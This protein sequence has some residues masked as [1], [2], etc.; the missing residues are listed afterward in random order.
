MQ[1]NKVLNNH[2]Y[3][4]GV[5]SEKKLFSSLKKRKTNLKG[6]ILV[7]YNLSATGKESERKEKGIGLLL[8]FNEKVKEDLLKGRCSYSLL[9]L[10]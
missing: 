9:N 7:A 10:I 8:S 2:C 4:K 3:F 5:K 6:K 1:A